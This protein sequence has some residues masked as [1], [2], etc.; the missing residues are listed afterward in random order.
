MF[1][2][3]LILPLVVVLVYS[4]GTR[5]P[6]GGYAPGFSFENYLNLPA[7]G[8]AFFNT[9]TLAPLGTV[10]TAIFAYPMAYYLAVK[11]SPKWRTM[12]LILVIV[13][14]W[15]S[16]LLRYYAWIMILGSQGIPAYLAMLGLEGVRII[17]TPWAVLVGAVYGF[18]PLMVLPIYVSLERLD[19]GLL[20]AAG[21]L[22]A[23]PPRTFLQVTL[24]LSLPG[25]ATGSMLTF[26][27]LMG[28]FIL[29]AFLGGGK[30][31][32]IGNALVDLFLQ[33]RN[34][35]FGAAVAMALVIIMFVIIF[36]YMRFVLRRSGVRTSAMV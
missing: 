16:Q 4:F 3:L 29:P 36:L 33:S 18:L 25:V 28:D 31:F 21:D 9:L 5:A 17:N 8:K 6:E 23:S 14:F 15:T 26:I 35:P 24:P 27:L 13:P 1:F 7:R 12:L 30:V 19:K 2:F 32:F 11:A 34:W 22:G 10:L 20:E